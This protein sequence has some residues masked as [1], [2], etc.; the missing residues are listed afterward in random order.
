MS[1]PWFVHELFERE[2]L[3]YVLVQYG[4][5]ETP[6]EIEIHPNAAVH[7]RFADAIERC[8]CRNGDGHAG[9]RSR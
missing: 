2:A 6:T 4:A 7:R 3:P 5:D 9:S 1:T 8:E